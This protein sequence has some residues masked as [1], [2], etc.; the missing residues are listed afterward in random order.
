[1]RDT[2]A[3]F[4]FDRARH[5]E[6]DDEK[7]GGGRRKKYQ[8]KERKGTNVNGERGRIKKKEKRERSEALHARKRGSILINVPEQRR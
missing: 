6:K 7:T 5:E 8:R 2:Y 1:M 3:V 4:L